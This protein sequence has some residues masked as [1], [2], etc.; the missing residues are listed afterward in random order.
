MGRDTERTELKRLLDRM[1]T[2]QGGLV[3]IGGEPGVGKTRLSRELMREAQQRG[4]L[5]IGA[6]PSVRDARC[7]F[8]HELIRTTL[9]SGL[10]RG[11]LLRV[12]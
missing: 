10:C 4:C 1:L 5:L 7:E 6:R 11:C 12:A 9:V 2:G 3:M 8:V